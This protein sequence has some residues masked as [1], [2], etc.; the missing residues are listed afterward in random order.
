MLKIITYVLGFLFLLIAA[1]SYYFVTKG[2]ININIYTLVVTISIALAILFFQVGRSIKTESTINE[3]SK[4]P[5]I[6]KLIEEAKTEEEKIKVLEEEK[7]KLIE[8]IEIESKRMFLIKRL[9]DLDERLKDSYK[10]LTPLLNEIEIH[11][12]ELK[13]INDSYSSSISL[14]EIE[15]IRDRIEAKREGILF[16]KFGKKEYEINTEYLNFFPSFLREFII[17]Y[18]KL[19]NK[20]SNRQ[21]R[22]K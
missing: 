3:L 20:I 7:E 8:H 13:Q 4:V 12:K 19:L 1:I 6:K 2:T 22:K 16:L 5:H 9:E 17:A 14:K 10:R 11:E 15:K 21:K 18:I